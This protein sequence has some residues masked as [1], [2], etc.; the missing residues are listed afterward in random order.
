MLGLIVWLKPANL[1]AA[2]AAPE[3]VG[4]A[5]VQPVFA[6]RCVMCHGEA[7]QSKGVRLDSAA[8]IKKNAQMVYQ[9]AVVQKTM[10]LNNATGI[11]DAERALIAQWFQ[12]GAPVN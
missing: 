2:A 7:L 6:Q 12:S 10:P 11:T 5:Q 9:Q 1:P 8:E 3:K 4:M